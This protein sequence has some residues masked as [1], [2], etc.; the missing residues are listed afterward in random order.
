MRSRVQSKCCCAAAA[1]CNSAEVEATSRPPT[2]TRPGLARICLL[3]TRCTDSIFFA[4]CTHDAQQ[5]LHH[6]FHCVSVWSSPGKH[7]LKTVN[8]VYGRQTRAWPSATRVRESRADGDDDDDDACATLQRPET[9]TELNGFR[10][11]HRILAESMCMVAY[12]FTRNPQTRWGH[13]RGH[14]AHVVLYLHAS[15]DT[16]KRFNLRSIR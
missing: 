3:S 13:N 16:C 11:Y 9:H 2:S 8:P 7:S 10:E 1:T 6:T 15:R 14:Q 5:H 12:N 4:D